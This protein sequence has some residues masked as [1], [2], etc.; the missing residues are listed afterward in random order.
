[1]YNFNGKYKI[2]YLWY[3][4]YIILA[5]LYIYLYKYKHYDK[6]YDNQENFTPRINGLYRPCVRNIRLK[7]E[8]FMN[9]YGDQYVI[10]KLKKWNIY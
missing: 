9:N 2:T 3:I 10:N 4:I 7:Y 5:L 8:N 1:M 6:I